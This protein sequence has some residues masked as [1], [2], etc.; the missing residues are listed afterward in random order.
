M[1]RPKR[2]SACSA[3]PTATGC[4][5]PTMPSIVPSAAVDGGDPA[6]RMAEMVRFEMTLSARV[7]R[8]V[9]DAQ[10][11]RI[12]PNRISGYHDFPEKQFRRGDGAEHAGA[13]RRGA[14]LS[15]IAASAERRIPGAARRAGSAEGERGERDR[16]RSE[17]AAEA[18]RDQRRTAEAAA[19]H[20]ARSRRRDRRRVW[21]DAGDARQERDLRSR[22]G[23]GDQGSAEAGRAEARRRRRPAHRRLARRHLQGR[24]HR[25]G[26][27]CAGA[28]A[29]AAIR[30]RQPARVHQRAGL[31]RQPISKAAKRS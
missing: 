2:R 23:S 16:R 27:V 14:D 10:T 5:R 7:L 17:A 8:Y 20:R 21:R 25:Q 12:D 1:R 26:G 31:H 28:T 30:S 11:G 9:R 15:R 4:R 22:T 29:L 13:Y 18:R 6:A 24:P 3:R 19:D